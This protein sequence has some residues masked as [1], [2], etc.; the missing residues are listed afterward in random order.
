VRHPPQG[1]RCIPAV[2]PLYA[3]VYEV[4]LVSGL[5]HFTDAWKGNAMNKL[6]RKFG[7]RALERL[8]P[9]TTADATVG[10]YKHCYCS[11]RMDYWKLCPY[12]GGACGPC[13]RTGEC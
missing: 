1:H 11:G 12:N 10:Y 2:L 5:G 7:D 9:S 8:V 3:S 6:L 4:L 13:R